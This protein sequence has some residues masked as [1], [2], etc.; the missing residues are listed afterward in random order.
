MT[1]QLPIVT[2]PKE[3]FRPGLAAMLAAMLV[4]GIF[5]G[6]QWVL[7]SSRVPYNVREIFPEDHP[8]L[9]A[10]VFSVL[11]VWLGLGPAWVADFLTRRPRQLPFLPLWAVSIGLVSWAMLRFAVTRE[12][13]GDVL[14]APTLGWGGDW[15]LLARFIALQG[16]VTLTLLIAGVTVGALG[17]L[18]WNGGL[19][20]GAM[21]FVYA[22]PWLVLAWMV[23]VVWANTDN[24]TEL[25]CATPAKWVGPFFLTALLMV[26]GLNAS[27]LCYAWTGW[28]LDS[29]RFVLVT[30]P[31]LV[32][33]GW[34]LLWL[35]L[36]PAVEKYEM[37]F[38]A[39][40]FLL[41]PDRNTY[42]PMSELVLRWTVVQLGAVVVLATGGM[43]ALCLRARWSDPRAQA[44]DGYQALRNQ[45]GPAAPRY[46]G[47]VY[48]AIT[49]LY[50]GFLLYGSLIP[51]N[52]QPLPMNAA[53]AEFRA[54]MRPI[55]SP[56]SQSDMVTNIAMMVPL[57]FCALGAW[58]REN[59]R[60]GLW[61]MALVIFA[62]GVAFS[63]GLEFSQ[64]FVPGRST[65]AHDIIAQTIGNLV[66]L[67]AW[68]VFGTLLTQWIR[69]LL[70]EID[71]PSLREKI[72]I[73]YV[74]LFVFY[75]ILPLYLTIS[76][77]QIWR[78]Y[79][80]GLINFQPFCGPGEL[81]LV[82]LVMKMSLYVPIG[83]LLACRAG[84]G[85]G[86]GAGRGR[87]P[88]VVAMVGGALFAVA[89]ESLQ[90]LVA[91]R[92]AT[93]TDVLLGTVGAVAGGMVASVT[94][95][96]ATGQGVYGAWWKCWGIGFKLP[97]VLGWLG[98]MVTQR[99]RGLEARSSAL[100]VEEGLGAVLRKPLGSMVYQA[101][102]LEALG[103]L[104]QE[105][106]A[107]L[108]LGMLL[109]ALLGASKQ[110][111]LFATGVG[112]VLALSLDL[113]RLIFSST[114]PDM[115]LTL[116]ALAAVVASQWAHPRFVTIFLTP[117]SHAIK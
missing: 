68:F 97:A 44:D 24:L 1:E 96:I 109:Q 51:L 69:G 83:Y 74:A 30:T 3:G 100:D 104:A 95:P 82:A 106:V 99:W 31:L 86:Q 6:I 41:G 63:F 71:R 61:W 36:E 12:S 76:A 101:G 116:T 111:R 102:P 115:T 88:W 34:G 53:L 60:P 48:L 66:G 87:H 25:I 40:Q 62:V 15:E 59:R 38:P 5:I 77:S 110:W 79:Q 90:V 113:S 57:T 67:A 75:S 72:L 103:R 42:L 45:D 70:S 108:I 43:I 37:V 56:W 105:F 28:R 55:R 114:L 50:A 17:R 46:P 89:V 84:R 13:L 92:I 65:S 22:V 27:A 9:S 4:G 14:G 32:G 98:L 78:K 94:G 54:L 58:S 7:G 18:D 2:T 80:A 81:D 35:G 23:V 16:I 29:K 107:F 33:P 85:A 11:L 91:S 8:G 52:F 93:V 39:V 73:T 112:I 49:G 21:A 20:R 117:T 47:A 26:I 64:V 19:R 10:A